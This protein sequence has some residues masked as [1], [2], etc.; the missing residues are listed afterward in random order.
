MKLFIQDDDK[1]DD[2]HENSIQCLTNKVPDVAR[3]DANC[4]NNI[5]K[6]INASLTLVG[7]E[8]YDYNPDDYSYDDYDYNIPQDTIDV[9]CEPNCMSELNELYQQCPDYD[10][11]L[12]SSTVYYVIQHEQI[13]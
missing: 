8:N 6:F 12:L 4:A 11:S 1:D 13:V 9:I 7:R 10:V 2:T 5:G 3:R